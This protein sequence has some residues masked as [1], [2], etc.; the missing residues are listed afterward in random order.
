MLPGLRFERVAAGMTQEELAE[1]S[2]VHR[3]TIG[4]LESGD[5]PARPTTIKKL[6]DALGVE[7][8]ALTEEGG[9]SMTGEAKEMTVH[10]FHPNLSGNADIYRSW[11]GS[12]E[13]W[14]WE[15][16]TEYKDRC[17]VETLAVVVAELG[18]DADLTGLLEALWNETDPEDAQEFVEA[19][20]KQ[21]ER[22]A[23]E[24]A[25]PG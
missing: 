7:T 8:R 24:L 2:G 4:K 22:R 10:A 17:M 12:K 19:H 23:A 11:D 9:R 18:E 15:A 21:I 20:R 1:R 6:A 13:A 5:R 25:E 14:L 16:L 3:D